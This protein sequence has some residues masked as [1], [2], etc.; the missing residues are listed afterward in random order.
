MFQ[1]RIVR[2]IEHCIKTMK[3]ISFQPSLYSVNMISVQFKLSQDFLLFFSF[4]FLI[5]EKIDAGVD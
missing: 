1:R 4:L 5:A 3:Q 2:V